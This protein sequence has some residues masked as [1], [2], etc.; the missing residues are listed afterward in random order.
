MLVGTLGRSAVKEGPTELSTSS[1]GRL[2]AN[3]HL[4]LPFQRGRNLPLIS[5]PKSLRFSSCVSLLHPPQQPQPHPASRQHLKMSP[6]RCGNGKSREPGVLRCSKCKW[7]SYCTKIC[8]KAHWKKH[9]M[10]CHGPGDFPPFMPGVF[11]FF[12]LPREIRNKVSFASDS[13]LQP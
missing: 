1:S 3:R 13:E 12:G 10:S 4:Q 11:N 9:K 2:H 5:T 6:Q 8:Q 7:K